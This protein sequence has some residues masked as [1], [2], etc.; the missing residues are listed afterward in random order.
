MNFVPDGTIMCGFYECKE[1]DMR[2]LD[3]KIVPRMMCPYCGKEVDMEIGPDD[4]MPTNMETAV[5][6]DVIEGEED[7]AR[8]DVLLNTAFD[9]SDD[10]WI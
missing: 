1:C 7:V 4:E 8:M 9:N 3:T 5:L 2:Y 6:L 10:S